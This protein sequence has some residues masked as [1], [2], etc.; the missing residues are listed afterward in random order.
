MSEHPL[1]ALAGHASA[2]L[3][4]LTAL[5]GYLPP[6]A[7]VVG[8]GWYCV[9]FWDRFVKPWAARRRARRVAERQ[10]QP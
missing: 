3:A 6:L 5:A 7:A 9:L 8:L 1:P 2:I 4:T 10:Q